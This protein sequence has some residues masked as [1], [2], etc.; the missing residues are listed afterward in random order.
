MFIDHDHPD[1]LPSFVGAK[2]LVDEKHISLLW[3]EV[4]LFGN[5]SINISPL[6]GEEG[7]CV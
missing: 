7:I 4:V 6:C 5:V 2:H 1:K 3:S